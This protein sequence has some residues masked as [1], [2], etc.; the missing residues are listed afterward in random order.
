MINRR[1]VQLTLEILPLLL[2]L[3]VLPQSSALAQE[4]EMERHT[5]TVTGQA[6]VTAVPDTAE[7]Q[8]GVVTQAPNAEKAGEQNAKKMERLLSD[9]RKILGEGAELKTLS[10]SL[11]PEFQYPKE[12][13]S[14]TVTGYTARNI[15][16]VQTGRLQDVGKVLDAAIQAGANQIEA[17]Q[18]IV[19]DDAGLRAQALGQAAVQARAKAQ[20]I[21]S[22]LGLTIARIHRIE[23]GGVIVPMQERTLMRA[24]MA[25]AE[26][27]VEP[28]KIELQATISLTAEIQ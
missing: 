14:P 4:H 20:A 28:G 24:E 1:S 9:L 8:I 7:I 19:K 10:Y 21:A 16:H 11:T 26:T 22:A 27:P 23:E 15:L 12:G 25:K 3:L 6:T 13:G 5:I 18:F 17:L 2:A